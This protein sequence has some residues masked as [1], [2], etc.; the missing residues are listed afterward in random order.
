MVSKKRSHELDERLDLLGREILRASAENEADAEAAAS[1][2]LYTRVR[3][4]IE[5]ERVQRA[6]G[7][8]WLSMLKVAWRAVPAMALVAIMAVVLFLSAGSGTR[9]TD[10][11]GDEAFFDSRDTRFEQLVFADNQVASSDDEV[12]ATILNEDDRGASQ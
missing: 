11:I 4:R 9:A 8:G 1:P 5:A 7:E 3:A 10:G 6:E 12:L 2:F